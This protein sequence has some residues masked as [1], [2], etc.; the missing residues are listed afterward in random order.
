M[1]QREP[2][3]AQRKILKAQPCCRNCAFWRILDPDIFSPITKGSCIH[4][5]TKTHCMAAVDVCWRHKKETF[6][7][8]VMKAGDKIAGKFR[9]FKRSLGFYPKDKR[10][11]PKPV[12]ITAQEVIV[13][14]HSLWLEY[15]PRALGAATQERDA[16]IAA[17]CDAFRNVGFSVT[18]TQWHSEEGSSYDINLDTIEIDRAQR[19][20]RALCGKGMR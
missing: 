2:T 12:E 13:H 16:E 7:D 3:K 11:L 17:I 5:E 1:M 19:C 15:P 6:L 8:K 9:A 20:L 4:P 10:P 18:V 14:S